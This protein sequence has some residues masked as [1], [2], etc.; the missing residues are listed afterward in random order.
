MKKI[1]T[2]INNPELNEKL[3]KEKNFEIIGKDIQYKEAIIEILE[4][5]KDIDLIIISETI[6]GQMTIDKLIKKIKQINEKIKII[7]ILEKENK[8]IEKILIKNNIIDIYYNNK[9][10]L[11]ELIKIINK[12]EISMEEEIIKLKKIIEEK[13]NEFNDKKAKLITFSGTRKSGKSTLSLIISK[14]LA[15]QNKVLLINGDLEKK[16][17]SINLKKQK[18]IYNKTKKYYFNIK[19]NIKKKFNKF[20]YI[21]IDLAENNFNEI[22]KKILEISDKNFICMEPK[23]P[24]ISELKKILKIYLKK[25]KIKKNKIM[26]IMNKKNIYSVDKKLILNFIPQEYK[27][28]EIK[29]NKIFYNFFKN[30][31]IK[32]E[33]NKIILEIKN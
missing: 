22:N 33:I 30:K 14:A 11:I 21:I 17:L 24:E 28:F 13:N 2:A 19:N 26:I 4:K 16:D 9:I 15:I 10:N 8:D 25:W 31:L 5:Y 6:S 27:I 18:K 23:I 1:I 29:E 12:K 7:F 20:D 3:K 32:K